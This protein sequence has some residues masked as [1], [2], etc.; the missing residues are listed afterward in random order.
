[1]KKAK[2]DSS[3]PSSLPILFAVVILIT[4]ILLFAMA[5][6]LQIS[7][8][9]FAAICLIA[10]A[11]VPLLL[12]L[13]LYLW[14]EKQLIAALLSF[15]WFCWYVAGVIRHGKGGMGVLVPA[16]LLP[17]GLLL[18]I[19][20]WLVAGYLLPPSA[21]DQ[22]WKTLRCLFTFTIGTNYPYYVIVDAAD[23]EERLV[24]R[25]DGKSAKRFISNEEYDIAG[26]GLVLSGCDYAV[27]ITDGLKFKGA[28][29][30]GVVFTGR[31]DQPV[32]TIDLRPQ[33]RS[34][35]VEALTK[36]GIAVRVPTFAPCQIE[37]GGEQP[38]LGRPFPYRKSAVFKAFYAQKLEHLPEGT[39]QR[40]WYELPEM[41]ARRAVQSIIAR[42]TFD[43]LCAPYDLSEPEKDPRSRIAAELTEQLQRELTPLGIH[44]LGGGIGNLLPVDEAV[45]QQRTASWQADWTRKIML[46]QAE[47]EAGRRRLVEQ[48]RADAQTSMILA[49]GKRIEQL[50]ATQTA[51]PAEEIADWFLEILQEMAKRPLV[52]R[53]LP[54]DTERIME[55]ISG[56]VQ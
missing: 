14:L 29:G 48:A 21:R 54:E 33:L 2:A 41:A 44:I 17:A 22:R 4:G 42:Y 26:P 30:P 9:V 15:A 18:G 39:K 19:G 55:R 43:E 50:G 27:V 32:Q 35:Q 6:T 16:T 23:E 28:K 53:L 47:G 46:R 45:L 25:V 38:S 5:W 1:M 12:C 56:A 40:K 7:W 52:R 36:D 34:L 20:L 31:Y 37:A 49:L 10:W 13:L 24:K 51:V 3:F 8:L 11:L